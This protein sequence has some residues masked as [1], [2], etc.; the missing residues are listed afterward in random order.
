MHRHHR[1][2]LALAASA[3][4]V[5][6]A[7]GGDDGGGTD[8]T[9][10]TGATE[11]TEPTATEPEG[12]EPEAT[13][14][15]EPSEEREASDVG[16]TEDTI[17]IGVAVADL[18]AVRAAGIS[19]PETLTTDHLYDRW[20]VF[21]QKWNAEGGINGRQVE[22]V[23]L[24]WDPLDPSSFD[25]LC[26]TATVDEE[27]FM[28]LNGTGLSSVARNC[29]LDAG[30][31]IMY[32]DVVG[33]AEL[34]TGLMI[35]LSPSSEVVARA[36]VQAWLDKNDPAPGTKLGILAN[37]TPAISA[38]GAAAE[39]VLVEA[40]F[41]V[42]LITINSLAGDNA[43]TNEEGAAAVGSF[44]A[45]GVEHVFVATP[46]TENTGFWTAAAA[47][48]LPFTLL[49]TAS[50]GCSTFGLSRAPA[51]A[52][53]SECVT[54]YDHPTSEGEGIRPDTEFEAEC[55][56]FFDESF[57]DYYGGNSMPGVPA[58]QKITDVNGK[59]L[60]SDYTPQECSLAN[61]LYQG[62]TNAGINPTR[63]SV[64]EAILALGEVPLA[65]SGGGV[66]SLEPGKPYAADQLHTVRVTAAS[67]DTPPDAD[68]LYNG[69]AAPVNCGIVI[70]DWAPID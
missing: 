54:A 53:G 31:P 65:M 67:V 36:G 64:I 12:T 1:L 42:Q 24:V 9:P 61:I 69:C 5:A 63:E 28:V 59:E 20:D 43:A 27:L 60:I 40:G 30:M 29:L 13:E 49:D 3:V 47:A 22:L 70:S 56:A 50:S 32:G 14:P 17:R 18:E 39:E 15:T 26:A 7:C 19:I 55:R 45:N 25:S 57:A 52:V 2:A 51:A 21:A 34:D 48:G 16:I 58:G 6:A 41:D 66:G 10:T 37:N 33:Q 35:S 38:A 4:L 23:R 62:L 44:Q 8:T 68:G 46:F 11:A